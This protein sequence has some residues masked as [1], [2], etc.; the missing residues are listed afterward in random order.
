MYFR[1]WDAENGLSAFR[2]KCEGAGLSTS[3][4]A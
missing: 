3:N 4:T 2:F 1:K